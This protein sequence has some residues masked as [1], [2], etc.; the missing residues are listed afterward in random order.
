[1]SNFTDEDNKNLNIS[2]EVFK[3]TLAY[4]ISSVKYEDIGKRIGE[5]MSKVLKK[6]V[7]I[8]DKGLTSDIKATIK[9]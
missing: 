4:D 6:K 1:M 2:F 8:E 3:K 7:T 5:I 9:D